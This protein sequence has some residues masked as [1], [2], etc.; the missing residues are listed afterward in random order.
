M[1]FK[2]HMGSDPDFIF[3]LLTTYEHENLYFGFYWKHNP[4]FYVLKIFYI[5]GFFYYTS[6]YFHFLLV[7]QKHTK[8][9]VNVKVVMILLN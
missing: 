4:F 3:D 5:I 1:D 8:E 9:T 7:N 2:T 6:Y